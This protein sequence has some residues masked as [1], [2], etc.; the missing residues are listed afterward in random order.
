MEVKPI[1]CANYITINPLAATYNYE[2][3]ATGP[4]NNI[5]VAAGT[6][7]VTT[8]QPVACPL[9]SFKLMKADGSG[10]YGGNLVKLKNGDGSF[11]YDSSKL[12]SD[13]L[14]IE[15]KSAYGTVY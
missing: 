15:F 14:Y 10:A 11:E 6:S 3:A 13:Y 9:N 8:T 7:W 1:N 12:G 4:H 2:V 5:D